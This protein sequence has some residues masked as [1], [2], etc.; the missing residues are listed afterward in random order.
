MIGSVAE[1]TEKL[2]TATKTLG[3]DRIFAQVDW[4]GLPPPWW[5]TRS[6]ATPPKSPRSCGRNEGTTVRSEYV[7]FYFWRQ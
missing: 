3:L 7:N 6:A 1:V 4:G 2:I 5:K